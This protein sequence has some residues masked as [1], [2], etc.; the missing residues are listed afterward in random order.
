M[1]LTP[2][3]KCLMNANMGVRLEGEN[4]LKSRK[5]TKRFEI[6]RKTQKTCKYTPKDMEKTPQN[7]TKSRKDVKRLETLC[8]Y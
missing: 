7:D 1:K 3:G 2:R 4:T 5:D 6:C 8:Y